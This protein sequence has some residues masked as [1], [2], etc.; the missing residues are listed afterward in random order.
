[1]GK[2]ARPEKQA[3]TAIEQIQKR[4]PSAIPSL[5]TARNFTDCLSR[6]GH[7]MRDNHLG[8]DLWAITKDQ[9]IDYLKAR[10]ETVSQSTLDQE[11][12]AI[13]KMQQ[14][15]THQLQPSER[16]PVIKSEL[17]QVLES[18]AYATSQVEL[19]LEHQSERNAIAT[20]IAFNAGLRAHELFCIR[21]LDERAPSRRPASDLKFLGRNDDVLYTVQGKG[22]LVRTV[23]I[24]K[25]LA[26]RLEDHRL[27]QPKSVL[28]RKIWY[29]TYYDIGGGNAWT[30][31]FS[32]ASLR[33]LDKT[34]GAHGLRHAYAQN[35]MRTLMKQGLNRQDALGVVSQEMGHFR[36]EI[37]E[38]YLR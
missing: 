5:G 37:T 32:D 20:E 29:K 17:E 24:D 1:M 33:A 36:P 28:D 34:H 11:R 27:A 12:Q 30:K 23:M 4:D 19:I 21:R 31:S 26:E 35:R 18:R 3:A 15:L 25:A 13:Q 9:A 16:L 2:F 6:V 10:A 22:G 8:R 14:V 7:W 38:V